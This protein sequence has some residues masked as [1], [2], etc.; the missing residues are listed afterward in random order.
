[1]K[2]ML[3]L[4]LNPG[5]DR[6]L[7]INAPAP[8][9][10]VYTIDETI[11]YAAGKGVNVARALSA[12]GFSSYELINILGGDT[13]TLIEAQ[14]R[15][16]QIN[17]STFWIDGSS[18]MNTTI[19]KTYLAQIETFNETGPSIKAEEI[20]A[21]I[22]FVQQ[23]LTRANGVT[24]SGSAVSGLT[25]TT[26]APLLVTIAEMALPL[27]VDITGPWLSALVRYPVA[28]L[29]VNEH[30]F[31]ETFSIDAHDSEAIVA[32]KRM[33]A[34]EKLV[35]TLGKEGCLAWDSHN[36]RTRIK[37]ATPSSKPLNTVGCGDSFF[38]GLLDADLQ[39]HSFHDA[40]IFASACGAANTLSH[41]PTNFTREA[42][43]HLIPM[44]VEHNKERPYA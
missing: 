6:T 5:F 31:R 9:P 10:H 7:V 18:R 22:A 33:H 16:D 15:Q 30:E 27:Y 24:I 34:I 28:I 44:I 40:C 17:A 29:K 32:F 35:I 23:K 8:S 3:I 38:A 42:V 36:T 1:M 41:K 14:C 21:F 19:H 20:G 25:P 26:L 12:L 37:G 4:N 13:G 39:G 43:Q 11:S 2:Q